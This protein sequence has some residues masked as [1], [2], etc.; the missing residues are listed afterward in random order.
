[1]WSSRSCLRWPQVRQVVCG[2]GEEQPNILRPGLPENVMAARRQAAMNEWPPALAMFSLN[3]FVS[4]EPS[5]PSLGEEK[6]K[7]TARGWPV[8]RQEGLH[9]GGKRLDYPSLF[10]TPQVSTWEG[11]NQDPF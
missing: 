7:D 5:G 3:L 4:K 1:M 8:Q 11:R 2:L 10:P 9:H 6:E